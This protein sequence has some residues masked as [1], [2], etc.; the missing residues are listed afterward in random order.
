MADYFT[1]QARDAIRLAYEAA[2]DIHNNYIGTEHLLLGL[3]RQGSGVAARVLE[4]NEVT[5]KRVLELMD[6]LI[7]PQKNVAI[8]DEPQYTPMARRALDNSHSEAER[9]KAPQIGTEHIL[10]AIL[11]EKACVASKILYTMGV[12]IQKIY[13]DIL[14]SM[15]EDGGAPGQETAGRTK[16]RQ[17][18]AAQ[19]SGTPTLDQYSRDL[20]ELAKAGK[21]DPVIGRTMEM[22]RVMQ[23]L[24]RRTKNNPCLIGEPGVGKT[25]VVEGLAQ[26]IV[27]GDVP[28]TIQGKRVVTLDLSGMIAGSKYRGEF[29]E[30]IKRVLQ[31]VMQSGNVLLFIDEIH[32]IIGAGGAEGAMDA[33]NIL[34]PSLARGELQ[35]IGAT[36][37]EEY[38]KY[39]EKDAALERRFQPITVEEPSEEESVS[40]LFGLRPR[41]EQHH[42]VNITDSAVE[43]AVHLSARYISD[44]FLPDKAIDLIDEAASRTRLQGYMEPPEIKELTEDIS[45]LEK[46][47]EAAVKAEEFE[48]A[49][50]LKK[51]QEK[52][53]AKIAKIREKWEKDKAARK[54][55][56]DEKEIADVVAAW[57]RIPVQK[58]T[59]EENERLKKLESVLHERVVGQEEAVRAV[60]KAIRRGRVGLKDPHRPIGSFLFLGPTGVGKTELCKALAEAMFGTEQ[61]LIR[62][63]MSEYMEKHSVSKMV[64]SPPGYVG[65]DEGGQ[66]SEKVRRN[67]YSVIL[68][69]EIEKAHPDVFNILLQV[70]DDGHITDAQGRK[71]DF[72]N[73][74]IIM[75]SNAGASRIV[76]PKVLGF[77]AKDNAETDYRI[78]KDNV[79]D[80]VRRIFKPEFLNRIDETIVFHQLN[81]EHMHEIVEILLKGIRKRTEAQ[82]D[83]R[84]IV[85]DEAKEFLIDKGYDP[86][87]G[88][89]PLKRAIQ[90]EMEDRLAEALL[91]GDVREGDTVDVGVREEERPEDRHLTFRKT[92][93][94]PVKTRSRKKKEKDAVSQAE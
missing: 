44:R 35:L 57:T 8:Q 30:R 3:M 53:Q 43:A 37:I 52:K 51:R 75:T 83:L 4:E 17:G 82:M 58:L 14:G 23:I 89:R 47:K 39:I 65:Y 64:G 87:Y 21:L 94:K 50:D 1:K 86:K 6:R 91:N 22:Q 85:S 24:S 11:R 36:T 76:A 28:E 38:R 12:N 25:A 62:V 59:E 27:A 9:F 55:V 54:L 5:E 71:I 40:I 84:L 79:M 81:R 15:G 31:E 20:T 33:S 2:R 29:E 42:K 18:S 73:T 90:T 66:L 88:A 69:D 67:P 7:S 63:D 92:E 60:S 19:D 80:E 41:Y 72:K 78:M 16:S 61:A 49:G 93:D 74:I 34:K 48:R 10:I 70:L 68:F 26:L 45:K 32:T 56:V 77:A 13:V 46:Q